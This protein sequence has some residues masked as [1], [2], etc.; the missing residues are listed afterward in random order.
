MKLY[1]AGPDVFR[2]DAM[3]WAEAAR[4]LCQAAGHVALIPLDGVETTAPGIYHANIDLIRSADAV[5]ANL[6]PFRGCEPD[7]GTCV[8]VGFALA[9]GKPVIGYL[10]DAETTTARVERVSGSAL[11]WRNGR[12]LDQDGLYVEDFG[13]PLNLMLAVPARI[14]IGGLGDAVQAASAAGVGL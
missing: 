9:L 1:L 12:P 2:P 7:S 13:L 3:A 11:E 5:L 6:N 8:E 14:V 4:Q 10:A